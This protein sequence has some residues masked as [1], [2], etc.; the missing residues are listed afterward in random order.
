LVEELSHFKKYKASAR[1]EKKKHDD[2]VSGMMLVLYFAWFHDQLAT[3][4]V[5]KI[6][7]LKSSAQLAEELRAEKYQKPKETTGDFLSNL[8]N[9]LF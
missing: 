5:A 9:N 6:R 1:G 8:K 2:Q 7:N 4:D 3:K